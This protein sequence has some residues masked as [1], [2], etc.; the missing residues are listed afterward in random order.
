MKEMLKAA[1]KHEPM[2]LD[3]SLYELEVEKVRSALLCRL[4]QRPRLQVSR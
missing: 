2:M 4:H 3:Q 1:S